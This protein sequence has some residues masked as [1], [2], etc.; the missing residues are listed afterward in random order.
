MAPSE[1]MVHLA[2]IS[3]IFI[4]YQHYIHPKP[5]EKPQENIILKY[6]D[7][8]K[9][10][11]DVVDIV[12]L[13]TQGYDWPEINAK[14]SLNVTNDRVRRIVTDERNKL[15]FKNQDQFVLRLL[16]MGILSPV[17]DKLKIQA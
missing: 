5:I 6:Y 3:F 13:R 12:H 4:V 8:R 15:G 14:L 10:K 1:I 7:S 16:D 9:V 11:D 2:G 17:S